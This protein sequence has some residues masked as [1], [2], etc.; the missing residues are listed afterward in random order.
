MAKREH[1][2]GHPVNLPQDCIPSNKRSSSESGSSLDEEAPAPKK[3]KSAISFKNMRNDKIIA[4]GD[5]IQ[6]IDALGA[7]PENHDDWTHGPKQTVESKN[8]VAQ[9]PRKPMITLKKPAIPLKK[10]V[11]KKKSSSSSSEPNESSDDSFVVEGDVAEESSESG[12]GSE[13]S[14]TSESSY[15]PMTTTTT[16]TTTTRSQS[17]KA[18]VIV[19][20]DE[21]NTRE[22]LQNL[23][24]E[25][26]EEDHAKSRAEEPKPINEEILQKILEEDARNH[27]REKS[28]SKKPISEEDSF[29]RE[30]RLDFEEA[31]RNRPKEKSTVPLPTRILSPLTAE[32]IAFQKYLNDESEVSVSVDPLPSDP[33]GESEMA[34]ATG[35]NSGEDPSNGSAPSDLTFGDPSPDASA[36]SSI[37]ETVFSYFRK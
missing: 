14:G 5:G 4:Q 23:A 27:P 16:T 26:R 19:I 18:D 11:P 7:N 24:L 10:P 2:D 32:D 20:E 33:T 22:N 1:D 37:L 34:D 28:E 6:V 3:P 9:V 29:N 12:E 21:A 35:D 17:K 30:L 8:P 13:S 15:E 31:Q 25:E 36:S